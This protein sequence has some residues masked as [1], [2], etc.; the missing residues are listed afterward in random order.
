MVYASPVIPEALEDLY[1][2]VSWRLLCFYLQKNISH[3]VVLMK[4]LLIASSNIWPVRTKENTTTERAS[5]E[6]RVLENN[7]IFQRLP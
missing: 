6:A 4:L 1:V 5:Q 2:S 7:S 3:V